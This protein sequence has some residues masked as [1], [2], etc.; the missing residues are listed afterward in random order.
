MIA[1]ILAAGSGTRLEPYTLSKHKCLLEVFDNKKV[2]DIELT[3]LRDNGVKDVIIAVGHFKEKIE[4]YAKSNYP[5]MNFIFVNNKKYASTNCIYS[6]WLCRE[7]LNEDTIF[8][9]GDL[10]FESRVIKDMI[11]SK[12]SNLMYVNPEAR[13]N[14]K[15][16]KVKIGNNDFIKEIGVNVFGENVKMAYPLYKFSKSSMKIWI[17]EIDNYIQQDKTNLYGEDAFNNIS[18]KINLMPMYTTNFCMEIDDHDDLL[19]AKKYYKKN[20]PPLN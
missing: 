5:N 2:I 7:H 8:L 6:M 11:Y 10:I 9:T 15:N 3:N 17:K 16:F 4:T 20:N 13:I 19:E 14:K 12:F 18:D 1:F